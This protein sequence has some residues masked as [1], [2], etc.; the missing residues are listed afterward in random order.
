MSVERTVVRRKIRGFM[1]D[2]N[3]S[4]NLR[5]DI[6]LLFEEGGLELGDR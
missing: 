3:S 5:S 1:I 6:S 2:L 4:R